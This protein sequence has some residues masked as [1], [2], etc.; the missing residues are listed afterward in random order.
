[1][2]HI[3]ART[4]EVGA[5][6]EARAPQRLSISSCIL[7][8]DAAGTMFSSTRRI[9]VPSTPSEPGPRCAAAARP[10]RP[11]FLP[12]CGVLKRIQASSTRSK[13]MA[14]V[15]SL[16][17]TSSSMDQT[18]RGHS[19]SGRGLLQSCTTRT[20][21]STNRCGNLPSFLLESCFRPRCRYS[22]ASESRLPNTSGRPPASA[23]GFSTAASSSS[24]ARS[25]TL[26]STSRTS[27]STFLTQIS[28]TRGRGQ[29]RSSSAR[30]ETQDLRTRMESSAERLASTFTSKKAASPSASR[31]S[32]SRRITTTASKRFSAALRAMGFSSAAAALNM[33]GRSMYWGS[34]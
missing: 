18:A 34:A 8:W 7:S 2:A 23:R 16:R 24:S 31:P 1:M 17:V 14:P 10:P 4:M 25:A 21:E 15:G 13:L 26:C 11:P 3:S 32:G 6:K 30:L 9:L 22:T 29:V 5:E 27:G 33:P 12:P 20:S 19:R 28:Q